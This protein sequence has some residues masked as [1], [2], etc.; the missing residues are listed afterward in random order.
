MEQA[1]S[2]TVM[3]SCNSGFRDTLSPLYVLIA[4]QDPHVAHLHFSAL[5]FI[6]PRHYRG[7][8]LCLD[9]HNSLLQL[10]DFPLRNSTDGHRDNRVTVPRLLIDHHGCSCSCDR[11]HLPL[12]CARTSSLLPIPTQSLLPYR[13][14]PCALPIGE[15]LLLCRII[16][17][18]SLRTLTFY[19]QQVPS[20]SGAQELA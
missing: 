17:M 2:Y 7:L 12:R 19:W 13:E 18:D 5:Y 11:R 8:I 3:P 14:C 6:H 9:F 15:E 4:C 1:A 20:S 10:Q 16:C